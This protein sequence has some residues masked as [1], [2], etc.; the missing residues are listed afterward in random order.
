MKIDSLALV[1]TIERYLI[2]KGFGRVRESRDSGDSDEDNR[3]A[4]AMQIIV[5]GIHY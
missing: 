3:Y 4:N 5:S 1:Q 2:A